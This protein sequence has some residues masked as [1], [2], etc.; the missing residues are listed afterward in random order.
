M[1]EK[2]SSPNA[3]QNEQALT[4]MSRDSPHSVAISDMGG[5]FFVTM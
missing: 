2:A 3:V 4:W 5:K 1:I